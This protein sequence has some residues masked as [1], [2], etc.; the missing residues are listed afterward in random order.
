ISDNYVL[1]SH[2][3]QVS[4]STQHAFIIRFQ[5]DRF[6]IIEKRLIL[7]RSVVRIKVFYAFINTDCRNLIMSTFLSGT[8]REKKKRDA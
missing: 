8:S 4:I 7:C 1:W 5:P 2:I 3:K 6:R